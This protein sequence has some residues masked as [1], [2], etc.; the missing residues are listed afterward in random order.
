MRCLSRWILASIM[1]SEPLVPE[2]FVWLLFGEYGFG[3]V[4]CCCRVRGVDFLYLELIA[5][6]LGVVE[7]H[8]CGVFVDVDEVYVGC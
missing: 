5:D 4:F 6:L 8:E 1:A 7:L 2:W 3:V